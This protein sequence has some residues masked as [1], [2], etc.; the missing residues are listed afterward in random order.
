MLKGFQPNKKPNEKVKS[1]SSL[2]NRKVSS[3][4][5][6]A[7]TTLAFKIDKKDFDKLKFLSGNTKSIE[8]FTRKFEEVEIAFSRSNHKITAPA[9]I[10]SHLFEIIGED[11]LSFRLLVLFI[12]QYEPIPLDK[13]KKGTYMP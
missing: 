12:R 8:Y 5:S 7:D 2:S 4:K 10:G 9:R 13:K 11:F 1:S 6:N 3:T